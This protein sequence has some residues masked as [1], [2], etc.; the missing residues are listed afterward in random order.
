[1]LV[2]YKRPQGT[3]PFE[4]NPSGAVVKHFALGNARKGKAWGRDHSMS[5]FVE[6]FLSGV[7]INDLAR[8]A[9]Y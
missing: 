7:N 3:F 8:L 1:M 2:A 9:L 6:N 5:V 4:Q